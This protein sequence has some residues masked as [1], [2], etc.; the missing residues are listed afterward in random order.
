MSPSNGLPAAWDARFDDGTLTVLVSGKALTD[1]EVSQAFV[2]K[3]FYFG[4]WSGVTGPRTWVKMW[5]LDGPASTM[6]EKICPQS[7]WRPK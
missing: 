6:W 5:R 4:V 2:G 1:A 3:S 7:I